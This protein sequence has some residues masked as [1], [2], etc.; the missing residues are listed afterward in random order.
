VSLMCEG[1]WSYKTV[2]GYFFRKLKASSTNWL[3]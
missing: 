1:V 3:I 2:L